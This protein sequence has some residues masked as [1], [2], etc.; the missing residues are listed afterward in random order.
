MVL[1]K[2]ILFAIVCLP[3]HSNDT[4]KINVQSLVSIES[5]VLEKAILL[6]IVFLS[7][8]S[9]PP[10]LEKMNGPSFEQTR[11]PFTSECVLPSLV[12]IGQV[13]LDKLSM[14]LNPFTK[15]CFVPSLV[16]IGLVVLE[17]I[18]SIYSQKA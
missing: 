13:V 6:A 14:T 1:K 17:K 4:C 3:F 8:H 16:E 12:E 5:V 7:F 2:A 15:G 18:S 10:P 11:I 9:N